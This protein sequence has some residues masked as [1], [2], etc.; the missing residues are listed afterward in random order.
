M[1]KAVIMAGGFGTRLRPLTMSI[2]KPMVPLANIP[3]MEHIV[4][5]LKKHGI[6]DITALLY[7]QPESIKEHFGD[8]SAFGITMNYVQADADY[9]TAGSVRN[10]AKEFNEPILVMSGD[11][12]TDIDISSAIAFHNEKQSQATILLTRVNDPLHYGIVMTDMHGRITRFLEKPSWGEVFTDTINSG[13]YILE[14]EVFALIPPDREYDFGKDLFPH[15]LRSEMN[16][17]GYI[18]KGYWKD[19]GNLHEYQSAC[20]DILE[21]N[22]A[23]DFKG[24]K[25]EY[26]LI[27]EQC[28]ISDS[29]KWSGRSIIG[30]RVSIGPNSSIHQ[31]IIGND[32]NIGAGA[33]LSNCI[34]W[35]NVRLGDR[36]MASY[37]VI[38]NDTSIGN[39]V[40]IN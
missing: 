33:Q 13:M 9:G 36:I 31:C 3:M 29:V 19:I 21:Y 8:G 25:S 23:I 35:N 10:A 32:V 26:G 6:T 37:D 40:T 28:N 7:Y 20:Q 39:G 4:N 16:L 27:G 24:S 11:V 30:D 14:P 12:L 15:L 1:K 17:F 2:P 34:I 5:L 38:C 22:V 18:T